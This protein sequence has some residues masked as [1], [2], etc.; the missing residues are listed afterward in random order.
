MI[1]FHARSKPWT[2]L[3]CDPLDLVEVADGQDEVDQLSSQ[4][5]RIPTNA[6]V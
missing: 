2:D 1:N 3:G 4:V 5:K 6:H